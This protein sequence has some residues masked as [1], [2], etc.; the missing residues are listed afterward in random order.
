MPKPKTFDE[1]AGIVRRTDTGYMTHGEYRIEDWFGERDEALAD[2]R[3]AH[4]VR[5]RARE[6]YGHRTEP[7]HQE[8]M[9]VNDCMVDDAERDLLRRILGTEGGK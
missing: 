2:L 4:E 8:G 1:V 9:S 5:A 3:D 7:I 6:A